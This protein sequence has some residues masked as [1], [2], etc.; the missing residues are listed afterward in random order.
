M[1]SHQ[2]GTRCYYNSNPQLSL[3]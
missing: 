3:W 1:S 2:A